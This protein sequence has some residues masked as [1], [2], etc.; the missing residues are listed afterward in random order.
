MFPETVLQFEGATIWRRTPV[1]RYAE[2]AVQ[3]A[4]LAG[5]NWW[6]LQFLYACVT[7]GGQKNNI[8]HS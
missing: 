8:V 3:P 2:E 6:K 5:A 4:I 1:R 7:M